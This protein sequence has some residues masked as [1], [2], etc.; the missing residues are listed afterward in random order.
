MMRCVRPV[1][2]AT[3][4][5]DGPNSS[6]LEWHQDGGKTTAGA[7]GRIAV[8][9]GGLPLTNVIYKLHL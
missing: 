9:F 8:D 4:A 3:T 5:V 7:N 2:L 6:Q 1:A